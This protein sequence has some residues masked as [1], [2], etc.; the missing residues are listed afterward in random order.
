MG[1]NKI[2]LVLEGNLFNF[3]NA[4]AV[5]K[6]NATLPSLPVQLHVDVF[7]FLFVVVVLVC[8]FVFF[9][10]FFFFFLKS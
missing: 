7:T 5:D 1:I 2:S 3:L 4:S 9:V 10:S 6:G 8:V